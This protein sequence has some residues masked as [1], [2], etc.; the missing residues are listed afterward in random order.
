MKTMLI[1]Y[2]KFKA[3]LDTVPDFYLC[4][5]IP[6]FCGITVFIIIRALILPSAERTLNRNARLRQLEDKNLDQLRRKE[7]QANSF[8]A[9][10]K[11]W[12]EAHQQMNTTR[13][14]NARAEKRQKEL[15]HKLYAAGVAMTPG[16]FQFLQSIIT[17]ICL[18]AALAICLLGNIDTETMLFVILIGIGAPT[19]ILRYYI[20][21]KITLRRSSMET[22]LP[23]VLDLLAISIGAGMGFDQALQYV[24]ESANGPLTD[25]LA[26]LRRELALGKSR[27]QAFKDLGARCASQT[28]SNFTS[29]VVQATEMGI[30]LHDMLVTQAETARSTHIAKVREKAAKASIKMLIP[31][32]LFI[33]P[34][35]FIVLLGPSVMNM[36]ASGL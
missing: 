3:Y 13:A 18:F 20:S 14:K 31:M 29:A 35:L 25:E 8:I 33:F 11:K 15:A 6:I 24:T 4:C 16:A 7:R 21:L 32:V 30:P 10:A 2:E 22:Q 23:D 5:I 28:V 1:V 34:C 12:L 19:I 26:V 36:M 27:E 17:V 9:K